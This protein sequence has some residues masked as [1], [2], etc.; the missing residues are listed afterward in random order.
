MKSIKTRGELYLPN[1]L[2]VLAIVSSVC[3]DSTVSVKL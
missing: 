1:K 2:K 3:I